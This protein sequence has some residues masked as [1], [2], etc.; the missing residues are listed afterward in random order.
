MRLLSTSLFVAVASCGAALSAQTFTPRSIVFD[1]APQYQQADLLAASGLAVGKP[2]TQATLDAVTQ[3]LGDIGVFTNITFT[4]SGTTLSFALEPTPE[5]QMRNPVFTNFVIADSAD[6]N[7]K[8]RQLVPLYIGSV[9]VVGNMQQTIERALE[10]ILKDRG[11]PATVTSIG[12][13]EET[14]T[15]RSRRRR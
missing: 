1:G 3:K 7:A 12:S 8:L 10:A 13:T 11:I 14:W 6:L 15:S 9:P 2:V 4:T 5:K